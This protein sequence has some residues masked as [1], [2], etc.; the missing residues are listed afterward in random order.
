MQSEV[1]KWDYIVEKISRLAENSDKIILIAIDGRCASGKTTFAG[2]L[3][4]ALDCN[5]F[6][7]DDYFLR[8]EQRTAERL[9]EPGGN[10]D[11]ERFCEEILT[12]L[13][14]DADSIVYRKFDCRTMSLQPPV[15][16]SPKKINIIE[17]AYSCHPD[18]IDKYDL[19]IFFDISKELQKERILNRNGSKQWEVFRDRWIPM[20]ERYFEEFKVKEQ[21]DICVD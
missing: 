17:G 9:K 16:V 4:E 8:P 14:E 15:T 7:M 1:K 11:R 19:K 6:H 12:P 18:L 5:V 2:Y 3:S 21:C 20:E 13:T 10:V